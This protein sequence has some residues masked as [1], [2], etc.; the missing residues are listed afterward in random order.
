MDNIIEYVGCYNCNTSICWLEFGTAFFSFFA[1]MIAGFFTPF[2]STFWVL[3]QIKMDKPA[4]DGC[5]A[6]M[7][8]REILEDKDLL[9][10]FMQH[11]MKL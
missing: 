10:L 4:V 5:V 2:I 6:Q 7:Q 3:R 1:G 11:Q 9:E 8:L